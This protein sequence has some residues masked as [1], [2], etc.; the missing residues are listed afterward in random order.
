MHEKVL[1]GENLE[2]RGFDGPF[3][4]PLC[5]EDS[6]NISHLFFNCPFATAVWNEVL[7]GWGE[8][9]HVPDNIQDCFLYWDKHYKGELSNKNGV[10][11]CWMKLPKLTCW[12]IWNER[13]HRIF[14]DKFQP[15]W[16]IVAKVNALLGEIVSNSKISSNKGN[17]SANEESWMQSLNTKAVSTV[18]TSKLEK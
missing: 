5:A 10:R 9:N 1:T 4:C 14:Q 6:E 13:N 17:L 12:C 11:A 8:D 18:A 7:N 16:K 15:A 2:K 3:R